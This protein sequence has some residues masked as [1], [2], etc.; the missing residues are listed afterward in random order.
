[1]LSRRAGLSATAGLSCYYLISSFFYDTARHQVR[2]FDLLIDRSIDWRR[3]IIQFVGGKLVAANAS[4]S[5]SRLRYYLFIASWR[6]ELNGW[7]MFSVLTTDKQCSRW[8]SAANVLSTT[9]KQQHLKVTDAII[10]RF[11]QR[12]IGFINTLHGFCLQWFY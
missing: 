3:P 7:K 10:G 11:A 2:E 4:A 9:N 6:T 5:G 8:S 1:M 12:Q